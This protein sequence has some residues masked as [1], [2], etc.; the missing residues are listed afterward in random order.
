MRVA[1]WIIRNCVKIVGSCGIYFKTGNFVSY[2]K[3]KK[4]FLNFFYNFLM[5][6]RRLKLLKVTQGDDLDNMSR[7][8]SLGEGAPLKYIITKFFVLNTKYFLILYTFNFFL[9]IK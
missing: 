4:L 8:R 9:I 7:S 2:S 6:V 5:S 1:S 3:K